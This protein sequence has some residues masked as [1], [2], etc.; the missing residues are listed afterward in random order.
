MAHQSDSF[1]FAAAG[2]A[3][4]T[5]RFSEFDHPQFEPLVDL[6]R[7]TDAA[8]V[9]LEVL[10]HDYE[11][12]PAANGPGTYMRAPPVVADELIEM[13][14]DMFGAATN[15]V[16]DYTHGGMEATMSALEE[17]SI[18]YAGLGRT[19]AEARKPVYA[20]TQAGRVGLVAACST[21]TTGSEAGRQRN[22]MHGRP[23]LSPLRHDVTYC[24]P[25]DAYQSL[26][27]ISESLGL[28]AYKEWREQLGFP[29][30][31]EPSNGFRFV[32]LGGDTHP[33][34]EPADEFEIQRIP[35][36]EDIESILAEIRRA[37]RQSE[38]VVASLHA[39]EGKGPR[40]TDESV[41]PF[42]QSFARRC[43]DA[44]ADVFVGHGPH[45]L[46]GIE[47]YDGAPI[48]YSLGNFVAQNELIDRLPPEVYDRYGL[49][50]EAVPVDVY[51][52]RSTNDDGEPAGFLSDRGY[53]ETVLPVCEFD[54]DGVRSVDL[55]PV[56]LLF[57]EPRSRRGRPVLADED[58]ASSILDRLQKLSDPYDTEI[59]V[60]S[61]RG[62]INLGD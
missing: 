13:G 43:I 58:V 49:G 28:E 32:A 22:D 53:F 40:S 54:D 61:K 19:L 14:F 33:S 3:M 4:I 16:M 17:R 60:E 2:D 36:Q 45:T 21:I 38:W 50:D 20:E 31:D 27:A 24:L 41:A 52:A 46:R 48:F 59:V 11:G 47:C 5:T 26:L 34:I 39:H 12:Y 29:L 7:G 10:L 6:L 25:E 62:R 51:D 56:D 23:G 15:H 18:P 1:T 35:D 9:N 55:Y 30:A 44:G 8:F 57:E 42:I 37:T